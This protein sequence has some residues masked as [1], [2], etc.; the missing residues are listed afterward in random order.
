MDQ[1]SQQSPVTTNGAPGA[2]LQAVQSQALHRGA[3]AFL[4]LMKS[5]PAIKRYILRHNK[6][7]S[8]SSGE[9]QATIELLRQEIKMLKNELANTQQELSN[10]CQ[11]LELTRAALSKPNVPTTMASDKFSQTEPYRA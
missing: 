7:D 11:E 6:V 1:G 4:D 10:T 8:S 2:E 5:D 3:Q 9:S